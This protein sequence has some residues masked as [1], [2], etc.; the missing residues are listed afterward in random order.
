MHRKRTQGKQD[1][2]GIAKRILVVMVRG[3]LFK[4]DFPL[5][6]FFYSGHNKRTVVSH[7]MGGGT[8]CRKH[9]SEGTLH[10]C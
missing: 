9:W 1:K 10:S 3:L 4:L 6:Y 5:A 8:N 7:C 2:P